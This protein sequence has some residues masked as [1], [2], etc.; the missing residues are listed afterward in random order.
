MD[1][2]ILGAKTFTFLFIDVERINN[3]K[4]CFGLCF[5]DSTEFLYLCIAVKMNDFMDDL[6]VWISMLEDVV[7]S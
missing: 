2:F 3:M 4:S 7:S 1:F 5:V 6:I